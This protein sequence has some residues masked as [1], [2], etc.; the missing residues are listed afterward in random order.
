M[1]AQRRDRSDSRKK[2]RSRLR[3]AKAGAEQAST[4]SGEVFKAIFDNAV[5]GIAIAGARSKMF[6]EVNPMFCRML[7]YTRDEIL[8]KGV[9]D[10]HPAEDLPHVV[11]EF[12]KQ[13]KGLISLS[14]DIPVKRKGTGASSMQTSTPSL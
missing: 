13:A 1:T 12:N 14:K 2:S 5:D 10:I 4:G 11:D 9:A 3:P 7:G 6:E 8:K